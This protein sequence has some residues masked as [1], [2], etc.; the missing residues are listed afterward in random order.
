MFSPYNEQVS[1]SRPLKKSVFP[2][3][4]CGMSSLLSIESPVWLWV[5][6]LSCFVV[7]I[8]LVLWQ[9]TQPVLVWL[10]STFH[11]EVRRVPLL[12]YILKLTLL[13]MYFHFSYKF[14]MIFLSLP[15]IPAGDFI[16]IAKNAFEW[17]WYF[18]NVISH[19][20]ICISPFVRIFSFVLQ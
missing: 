16:C 20:K 6:F 3:G 4:D 18:Y 7:L 12:L 10:S 19:P 5:H 9:S 8:Y 17:C 2:Q 14:Q 1:Q 11:H 15:R 13:F